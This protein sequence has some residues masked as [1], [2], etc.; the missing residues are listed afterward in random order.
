M[1]III[2]ECFEHLERVFDS[3]FLHGR[4]C[5]YSSSLAWW[6][7]WCMAPVGLNLYNKQLR[8]ALRSHS[9]SWASHLSPHCVNQAQAQEEKHYRFF[10]WKIK[11]H[12]T[13]YS[14]VR[15]NKITLA[16]LGSAA[17][18]LGRNFFSPFDNYIMIISILWWSQLWLWNSWELLIL[19]CSQ[20][21][22][23]SLLLQLLFLTSGLKP[24]H[25]RAQVFWVWVIIAFIHSTQINKCNHLS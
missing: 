11:N 17:G 14:K 24:S 2:K 4:C 6:Q 19:M 20:L 3:Q 15:Q 23:L 22:E 25:F 10:H 12:N 13:E 5:F 21:S 8:S 9:N 16:W 1:E 7:N 18:C